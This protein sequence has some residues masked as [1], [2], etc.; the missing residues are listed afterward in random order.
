MYDT[1]K[2]T[3]QFTETRWDMLTVIRRRLPNSS[4]SECILRACFERPPLVFK[5]VAR[6]PAV[7]VLHE[8]A[9]LYKF[10]KNLSR[11]RCFKL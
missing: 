3:Q 7:A 10:G 4:R 8:E 9:H 11:P 1:S 5:R 2:K 6:I